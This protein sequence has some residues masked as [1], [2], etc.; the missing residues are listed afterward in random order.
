MPSSPSYSPPRPI[1][2]PSPSLS[3]SRP[4]RSSFTGPPPSPPQL[5]VFGDSFSSVF[6]LAKQKVQVHRFKGA[7]ARGLDSPSSSLQVGPEI[8]R[9]L[10]ATRPSSSLLMFGA[11]DLHI[12]Y[13]WQLKSKGAAALRPQEWVQNV[14][15]A[16]TG[17]LAKQALPLVRQTGT[18]VYVAAVTPPI[19]EDCYLESATEKYLSKEGV[20]PLPPLSHASQPHDFATRSMMVVRFNAQLESFCKRHPQLQFVS[21]SRHLFSPGYPQRVEP[22]FKDPED[23]TNI[24]LVWETTIGLWCREVPAL[25]DAAPTLPHDVARLECAFQNWR[26]DKRERLSRSGF[27]RP[28]PA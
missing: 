12:N 23:P 26:L 27:P 11:V 9:R 18:R 14:A 16:Y 25:S 19:V 20:G 15:S 1:R 22:R 10:E 24:H 4:R 17:F 5:V 3:L 8:I 21:I 7:S 13:L 2:P 6:T 28:V